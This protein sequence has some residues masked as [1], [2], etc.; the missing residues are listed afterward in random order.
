LGSPDHASD[1]DLEALAESLGSA[2]V[3]AGKQHVP[4]LPSEVLEGLNPQPGQILVDL[5][6]GGGGHSRLL[7]ERVGPTGK[8]YAFDCD[9]HQ[10]E[11]A[12]QRLAG[13]P[14]ECFHARYD[15]AGE[16][17]RRLGVKA[18]GILADLGICSEQLDDPGRGLAFRHEGP[19]DMRLDPSRGE[20]AW[21]LLERLD[22]NDLTRALLR[23][24]EEKQARR[25]VRKIVEARKE[26]LPW[27]TT[28]L[29]ELVR[30]C[31]PPRGVMGKI[32]PATRTFQ[33]L[34]IL[35]NDELAVLEDMLRQLPGWLVPGGLA[36]I[37]S[38]HSLEDRLVKQAF[39][40]G[41]LWERVTRK[42]VIAGED[43]VKANP[44]SRSA[45]LRVARLASGQGL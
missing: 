3:G 17:L 15:Q 23:Y 38:F 34:R 45:K 35:V 21:K 33:G 36:A 22:E 39:A 25:I 2:G 12:R 19:L 14:V 7:A 5:T 11:K 44:R 6:L 8:V 27:T 40:R 26:H 32:D 30:S 24:G 18:H 41:E 28:R 10:V 4:V 37:I 9:P 1:D 43:E 13:L 31:L 42:P 29:A 20:P 16:I